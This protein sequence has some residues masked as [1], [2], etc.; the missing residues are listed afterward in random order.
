MSVLLPCLCILSGV[1]GC[2]AGG[3][4]SPPPP[5]ASPLPRAVSHRRGQPRGV[6]GS[7]P[8]P[9][10]AASPTCSSAFP[11]QH[12]PLK[13]QPWG[14]PGRAPP[15]DPVPLTALTLPSATPTPTR[16]SGP[17]AG[18]TPSWAAAAHYRHAV[19]SSFPSYTDVLSPGGPLQ[20]HGCPPSCPG[21]A[22]PQSQTAPCTHTV[23][24]T[25]HPSD[26]RLLC[27][28]RSLCSRQPP[29]GSLLRS[30]PN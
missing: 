26:G 8:P 15:P 23:K 21:L 9:T 27:A 17:G 13:T 24:A 28:L 16:L 1:R 2:L 22:R 10:T 3:P 19:P 6:P 4:R 5:P 25:C 30:P 18:S 14:P 7:P 12:F 20:H 29:P 11:H